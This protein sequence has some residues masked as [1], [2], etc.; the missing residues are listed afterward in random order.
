MANE[1]ADS[2]SATSADHQARPGLPPGNLVVKCTNCKEIL[3]AREWEKNLKVCSRC[4]YHFKLSAY[5]RIELLVDPGSFVEM[6][7]NIASADPLN[8]VSRTKDEVQAYSKKLEDE[9]KKVGWTEA[10][11]IGPATIVEF[12]LALA[13][14]IFASLA[15]AWAL[16]PAKKLRE[17]SSWALKDVCRC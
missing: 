5:E 9:Q 13:I 15:A 8:F 17:P 12:P 1:A 6:D 16:L 10:V 11:V 3:I 7:T 4:N 14:M 2:P